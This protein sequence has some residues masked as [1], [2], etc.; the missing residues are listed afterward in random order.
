MIGIENQR[1]TLLE[2]TRVDFSLLGEEVKN[3]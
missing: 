1:K 3:D 2:K